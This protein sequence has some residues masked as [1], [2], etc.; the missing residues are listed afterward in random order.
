MDAIEGRLSEI[1]A[2]KKSWAEVE[3]KNI[4]ENGNPVEE[5]PFSIEQNEKT[6]MKE[7]LEELRDSYY[8]YQKIEHEA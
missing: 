4:A 7:I 5:F 3:R 8:D 6:I 2:A 1:E